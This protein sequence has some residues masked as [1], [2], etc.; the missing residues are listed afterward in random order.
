MAQI[1]HFYPQLAIIGYAG[2]MDENREG[3][4][5]SIDLQR[6]DIKDIE[7]QVDEAIALVTCP[8]LA[9]SI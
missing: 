9:P 7:R 5:P 8:P 2:R 4:R 3:D 1:R 6:D